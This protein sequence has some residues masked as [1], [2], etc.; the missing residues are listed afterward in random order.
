M[1]L[2]NAPK[3]ASDIEY[4]TSPEP[5]VSK[6]PEVDV[7]SE[8]NDVRRTAEQPKKQKMSFIK[9]II[10]VVVLVLIVGFAGFALNSKALWS[11][12]KQQTFHAVFLNSGQ[13]YFGT[14]QRQD[15]E[16]LTLTNVFYVQ[17]V[18]QQVPAAKEGDLPTTT[19]VPKLVKKGEEFYGPA[20]TIRI[21]RSQVNVIEDLAPDSQILKEIEARLTTK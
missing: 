16:Y 4:I 20:N 12:N 11:Q 5:E 17:M 3:K 6:A 2:K 15:R 7:F 10:V 18:D 9:G 14:I 21:N 8:F 13:V 1:P 19:Q